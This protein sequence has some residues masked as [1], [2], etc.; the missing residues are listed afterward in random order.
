MA[1]DREFDRLRGNPGLISLRATTYESVAD[2]IREATASLRVVADTEE[3][4]AKSVD[5]V[6]ESATKLADTIAPAESRYRA[7]A[8]ALADYAVILDEAIGDAD[9]AIANMGTAESTVA[10]ART[11]YATAVENERNPSAN[12]TLTP[13]E[14][15]TAVTR[16][17]NALVTAESGLSGYEEAWRSARTK[18][19]DAARVAREAID[20]VVKDSPLND[21]FWDNWGDLIKTI[22]DVAGVLAIFLAWVPGLGQLL[23]GLAALGA[24]IA[25]IEASVKWANGE[26]SF[27]EVLTAVALGVVSVF[28]GRLLTHFAKA[29]KLTAVNRMQSLQRAAGGRSYATLQ[30]VPRGTAMSPAAARQGLKNMPSLASRFNIFEGAGRGLGG[31]G[32]R[33]LFGHIVGRSDDLVDMSRFALGRS[34]SAMVGLW[35]LQVSVYGATAISTVNAATG[36]TDLVGSAWESSRDGI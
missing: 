21:G 14:L 33:S 35:G 29:S 25:V 3:M 5:A 30:G 27:L 28:G 36:A 17:H 7:T 12:S 13:A 18:K 19:E 20:A 22:C 26:G 8:T 31:N 10:T 16:A 32:S 23:I 9:T 6:R 4:R 15:A 11:A 24:L 2:A 1:R 34:S